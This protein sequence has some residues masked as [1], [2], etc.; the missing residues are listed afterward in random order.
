MTVIC[1]IRGHN[2][3]WKTE[4][5]FLE[6]E[7]PPSKATNESI[8]TG[9]DRK[10]RII[11]P[12]CNR[13]GKDLTDELIKKRLRQCGYCHHFDE[14]ENMSEHGY[15]GQVCRH[16]ASMSEFWETWTEDGE[17][18]GMDICPKCGSRMRFESL[19]M[20]EEPTIGTV[21]GTRHWCPNCRLENLGY[22]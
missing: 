2:V 11:T 1:K 15:F 9:D 3:K 5:E 19:D 10:V 13:C 17:I 6:E 12:V 22:V 21:T 16:C 20:Y 18:I 4:K 7:R 14:E 8:A